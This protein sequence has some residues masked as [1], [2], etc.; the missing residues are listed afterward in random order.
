MQ[1]TCKKRSRRLL[2]FFVS[3]RRSLVDLALPLVLMLLLATPAAGGE[4]DPGAGKR[5]TTTCNACHGV[6]GFK[7]MPRLGGQTAGYIVSALRAYKDSKRSHSTMRDV[8]GALSERDIADLAAH[9]AA[10]PRPPAPAGTSEIAAPC[11][12]CHGAQGNEPATPD[13]AIIAGQN[14]AYLEQTLKEYRSGARVHAVMQ[15]QA[16]GLDDAKV[17]ELAAWFA[18][19]PALSVK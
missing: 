3:R 12:V 18:A 14:A 8:A 2:F 9:Y 13:V 16:A 6:S 1:G 7:S 15:E 10:I 19:R 17:A 11:A 4:G 5:K